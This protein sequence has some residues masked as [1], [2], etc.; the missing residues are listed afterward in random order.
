V[1]RF[2]QETKDAFIDLYTKVDVS[3]NETP[4]EA[5]AEET[6][7]CTPNPNPDEDIPF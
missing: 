6:V 3:T 7:T 1:N 2:D 4:V 5:T